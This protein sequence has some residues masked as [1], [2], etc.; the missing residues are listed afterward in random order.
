M[1]PYQLSESDLRRQRFDFRPYFFQDEATAEE[2][3]EQKAYQSLLNRV[4][5]VTVGKKCFLSPAATITSSPHGALKTGANCYVA[6]GAHIIDD[7]TFGDDCTVNNYVTLNGKIRFGNGIRIGA[8]TCMMGFNH[9]FASI[10]VPIFKQPHT[11]KG[12]AF[13]DDVWIGSH[14]TVLDGVTVGSHV[15][16]AGGAVVTKDVPDY[17]IVGGNPAKVIRMRNQA[18]AI[19]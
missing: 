16:L 8:Y 5:G 18:D 6:A 4:Y 9:G 7:V 10:D 12:I 13:G 2:K 3:A 15:I 14:V 19:K 1:N 11:S 17:A